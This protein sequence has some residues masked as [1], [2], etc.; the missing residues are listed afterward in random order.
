MIVVLLLT[1]LRSPL[2]QV[3]Q[4]YYVGADRDRRSV[5]SSRSTTT[6]KNL[7]HFREDSGALCF[8]GLDIV[9]QHLLSLNFEL[10]QGNG[11]PLPS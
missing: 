6:T 4:F 10:T 8:I 11:I 7:I 2:L 1:Y 5:P 9:P 3:D